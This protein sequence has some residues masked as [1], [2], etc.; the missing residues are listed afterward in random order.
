[1]RIIEKCL[2][3]KA[4]PYS[5]YFTFFQKYL[6]HFGSTRLKSVLIYYSFNQ[7]T[8]LLS[9]VQPNKDRNK[10]LDDILHELNTLL[11]SLPDGKKEQQVS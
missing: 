5:K 1:M 8:E 3:I 4:L 6:I 2:L 10:A 9:E 7:V 11:L